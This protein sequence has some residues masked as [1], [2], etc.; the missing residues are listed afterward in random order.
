[1]KIKNCPF[2]GGEAEVVE[3]R[4]M[5]GNMHY[6]EYHVKC[7][8]C[9]AMTGKYVT[10]GYYGEWNTERDAIAAWNRRYV[11]DPDQIWLDIK[12]GKGIPRQI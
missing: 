12:A 2:C 10:G 7:T 6:D 4:H 5:D 11:P 9:G 3:G 8:K 1:M